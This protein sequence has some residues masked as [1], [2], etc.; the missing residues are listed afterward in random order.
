ML[1]TKH[2][3]VRFFSVGWGWC[4]PPN[5][6]HNMHSQAQLSQAP[7]K[8]K[9]LANY[10]THPSSIATFTQPRKSGILHSMT[11]ASTKCKQRKPGY[12]MIPEEIKL[13]NR[14]H[15]LL[16]D[17]NLHMSKRYWKG[18]HLIMLL[19]NKSKK[20]EEPRT[21]HRVMHTAIHY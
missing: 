21:L 20:G 12:E 1:I 2:L 15:K 17:K 10:Q 4:R 18:K 11:L 5:Y 6:M 14:S 16:T 19:Q 9:K 3:C 7:E 13:I 8:L